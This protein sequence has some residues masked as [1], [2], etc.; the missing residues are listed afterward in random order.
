MGLGSD[1]DPYDALD[2][3]IIEDIPLEEPHMPVLG[4]VKKAKHNQIRIMDQVRKAFSPQIES[5]L[6]I[7]ENQQNQKEESTETLIWHQ[8]NPDTLIP[9][10]YDQYS[11]GIPRN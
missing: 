2:D 10:N 5:A 9:I 11:G 8:D 4:K 7:L 1:I 6:K 3:L